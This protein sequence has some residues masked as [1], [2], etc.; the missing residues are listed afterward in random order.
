M[1]SNLKFILGLTIA[2]MLL[3]NIG[4]VSADPVDAAKAKVE[5]SLLEKGAGLLVSTFDKLL[6]GGPVL[7]GVIGGAYSAYTTYQNLNEKMNMELQVDRVNISSDKEKDYFYEESYDELVIN[8]KTSIVLT[9][10]NVLD[11]DFIVTKKIETYI[12]NKSPT[13]RVAEKT[14]KISVIDSNNTKTDGQKR[15]ILFEDGNQTIK[16]A[17]EYRTLLIRYVQARF[18]RQPVK[19]SIGTSEILGKSWYQIFTSGIN[20]AKTI[21]E[22]KITNFDDVYGNRMPNPSEEKIQKFHLLFNSRVDENIDI[23]PPEQLD[24]TSEDGK[25]IGTTGTEVLPRII[26]DWQFKAD[27]AVTTITSEKVNNKEWC[28]VSKNGIY[29]DATQ[30]TIEALQ[31][32]N[33]INEYVKANSSGFTCPVNSSD[34]SLIS[35]VNNVGITYL[36]ANFA[37]GGIQS[38]RTKIN[39]SYKIRGNY[40]LATPP[41]NTSIRL[42]DINYTVVKKAENSF[43]WVVLASG[44]ESVDSDYLNSGIINVDDKQITLSAAPGPTDTVKV[45]IT[46]TNF[47]ASIANNETGNNLI[48]NTLEMQTNTEGTTACN[49]PKTSENLIKYDPNFK[50]ELYT[51]KAYLMK[52]GYSADFKK[53]FDDYYRFTFNSQTPGWYGNGLITS[54]DSYAP[55]YKYFVDAE[56]FAFK[57]TYADSVAQT[58]LPGPGRYS[59]KLLITYDDQWELFNDAGDMTGKIEIIIDKE[60]EPE[61]DSSV[62]YMPLNG[63]VGSVDK[64]RNGYGVDYLQDK[65]PIFLDSENNGQGTMY[66]EGYIS[67]NT[68]STIKT[69]EVKD[70]TIMN[71]GNERGKLLSINRS[72]NNVLNVR[73]IPSRPTPV[74][75]KVT[76]KAVNTD[77]YVFYKLSIGMPQ[78][79]G[80][81]VANPGQS[82]AYWTGFSQCNDFTGIPL[83]E[84]FLATHDLVSTKSEL[85]PVTQ[86]QSFSYGVE[87]NKDIITRTGN[88]WMYGIFYTPSNFRTGHSTS[89]LYI[90]SANDSA[91]LYTSDSKIAQD[92]VELTNV[93]GTASD[94]RSMKHIF[95]LVAAKKACINYDGSTLDV[96]YNPKTISE[97][98][99]DL[100]DTKLETNNNV[101]TSEFSCIRN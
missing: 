14:E 23:I 95:D 90:D 32:I 47:D 43:N 11:V 85:A 62:Y 48:D 72:Q 49:I 78:G 54:T 53:D 42:F 76:N 13:I 89:Y 10:Q 51:F 4:T 8:P 28:D 96:V 55:L 24:C 101:T 31:K 99:T 7:Y 50:N 2:L 97:P 92:Q 87:W 59:I 17:Y 70:F 36:N 80:G 6:A 37:N 38:Q 100:I 9:D 15:P 21:L 33:T 66:T 46:L 81:E 29:C 57:P 22:K 39:V 56:K 52:D 61:L 60:Q 5:Q 19:I 41:V 40:R 91:G 35:D 68:I 69:T 75:L 98:L 16:D 82:L 79:E 94:V 58:G 3:V 77:A 65:V 18:D 93:Y 12:D 88:V 27:N 34:Q 64:T 86:S 45:I 25:P 83:L 73:Y 44:V 26:F 30:F 20:N 63:M 84:S 67:S 71:N 74:V 1:K